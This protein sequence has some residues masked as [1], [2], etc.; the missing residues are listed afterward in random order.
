M[1]NKVLSVILIALIMGLLCLT[2]VYASFA[3]FTDE[4]ADKQAQEQIKEQEKEHKAVEVMSS[5]NYLSSLQVE[6][7]TLTPEF[8]KQTL[9][10]VINEELKSNEINIKAITSNEKANVTGSGKIKIEDSKNE[11]RVDVTAENGSVRTYIIKLNK[12]NESVEEKKEETKLIPE[13]ENIIEKKEVTTGTETKPIEETQNVVNNNEGSFNKYIIIAIIA[14]IIICFF[15][16]L[17]CNKKS[18]RRKH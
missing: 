1:K 15:I 6:G 14:L 16:F 11:Y 9:E 7:Y 3:D 13:S 17:K 10:Y 18:R 8:D 5:D 12:S 4:Q 2:S